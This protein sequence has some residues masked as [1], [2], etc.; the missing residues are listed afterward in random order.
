MQDGKKD[1]QFSLQHGG[2]VKSVP[3][4]GIIG[5][6]AVGTALGL[7]ISR[8]GWPLT[9]VSSRDG[10]RRDRFCG[11]VAGVRPFTEPAALLEVVELVLLAVPDDVIAAVAAPLR[12]RKGQVLAHTS[13]LLEAKVLAPA[14]G[15]GAIGSFHPLVSFTA[16]V[17]RSVAGLTGATI[18][19]DGDEP[20]V[21]ILTDLAAAVGGVSLRLPPGTKAAYHA[22]AVMASGGLVALL[23]AVAELGAAAGLDERR[24]LDVYSRLVE[25]TLANAGA[26]G[27]GAALTGPITRA[28][29]GT[30]EAHI[31][32]IRQ[33]APG[34][35]DLYL[36]AAHRE[37]RIAERRGA[38]SPERLERVRTAL[39]KVP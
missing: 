36:A 33:L 15:D 31:A 5:A 35:L 7:A 1:T 19:L 29:S 14:R 12:L 9:A 8:A 22:A 17:E 39:A 34:V 30:L 2:G 37:L 38:L 6:G 28:D 18:A 11:L 4:V 25:Q 21:A 23:D 32:A 20:A 10:A 13:G 27:V 3:A 26:I 24:S 16:D